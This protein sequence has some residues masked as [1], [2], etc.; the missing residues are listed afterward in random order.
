LQYTYNTKANGDLV[1]IMEL[2][3]YDVSK[4][5]TI[6]LEVLKQFQKI[7]KH[8]S[9]EMTPKIQDPKIKSLMEK[10]SENMNKMN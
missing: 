6:D 7:I 9:E 3:V 5:T 10:V 8:V 2:F 4:S 1:K